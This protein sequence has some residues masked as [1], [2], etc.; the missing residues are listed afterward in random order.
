MSMELMDPCAKAVKT[1]FADSEIRMHD[2]VR[3][4]SV[5]GRLWDDH[6]GD[7]GYLPKF[8]GVQDARFTINSSNG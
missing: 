8:Y 5:M 2:G 1:N 7:L 6:F 3:T 4:K